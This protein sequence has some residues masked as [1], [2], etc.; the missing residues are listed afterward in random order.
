MERIDKIRRRREAVGEAY[1]AAFD[2]RVVSGHV[3]NLL[4]PAVL[5]VPEA[6][7]L[8]VEP[9]ANCYRYN[10]LQRPRLVAVGLPM[11]H[12]RRTTMQTQLI[13]QVNS[14]RLR[15]MANALEESQGLYLVASRKLGLS[16]E[17]RKQ[18]DLPR[19]L[20]E[21]VVEQREIAA[22]NGRILEDPRLALRALTVPR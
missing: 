3:L 15:G 16:A 7:N 20:A 6:L 4:Q 8:T 22:E 9:A 10:Q 2:E 12:P 21:R 14:L 13:E 19:N 17:R 1:A 18:L 11:D 5:H